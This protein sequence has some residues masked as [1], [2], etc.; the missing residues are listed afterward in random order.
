MPGW[1]PS[2]NHL[3]RLSQ[4]PRHHLADPALAARLLGA[5]EG[6]LL[7]GVTSPLFLV[8][9]AAGHPTATPRDGTLFGQ[10]FES[11]VTLSVRVYAQAAEAHVRHLRVQDG[12]HEVDIIVERADHRVLGIEVKLSA[13]VEDRDVRHVHWLKAQLGDDVLDMV[14]ITTGEQ[15]Y[16]RADGVAVV[17]ATL[18]GI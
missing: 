10:L 3:A 8:G 11:L 15:A 16:R 9:G 12:R 4:A 17:P 2:R 1:L 7:T 13:S 5:D 6:A 14:V 18:L